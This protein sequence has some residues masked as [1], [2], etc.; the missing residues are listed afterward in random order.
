MKKTIARIKFKKHLGNANQFLVTS[1]VALHHL[2]GSDV[3][4]APEELHT[5]W[6][7]KDRDGTIGR[8]R[9]FVKQ[10]FLAWAV[11]GIDMYVS[12]L[13]KS[14]K[15]L[16][17]E[18]EQ[19]V[20]DSAGRSVLKKSVLLGKE[21]GVNPVILAL[22]DVLVTWRNNAIHSLAE[23]KLMDGHNDLIQKN[24]SWI[25]DNFRGLDPTG[26]TQKAER[27]DSLTFKET[28]SLI[29]VA[30]KYVEEVDGLVISNLDK[31]KF[32]IESIARAIRKKP[33]FSRKYSSLQKDKRENMIKVWLQNN[34]AYPNPEP[35]VLTSCSDIERIKMVNKALQ[36]T[37]K[38]GVTEL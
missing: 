26:L 3:N 22:T 25:A 13:N 10:S 6:S 20:F 17:K 1:M 19:L 21:L 14:P 2:K 23:N 16:Q 30:Q 4:E 27:G 8:S 37:P 5:T 9:M 32:A 33:E 29:N 18:S 7:P 31:E 11:D 15:Y 38:S 24:K 35:E 28:A 12:L 34:L 36:P